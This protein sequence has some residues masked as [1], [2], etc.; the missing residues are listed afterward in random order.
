MVES[1][2]FFEAYR[3]VLERLQNMSEREFPFKKYIVECKKELHPPC[4]LRKYDGDPVKYDFSPIIASNQGGSCHRFGTSASTVTV[5]DLAS[6]PSAR[7]LGLDNS[8]FKALQLALTNEF[9]VIQGP[10]G[11]GKTYIG[12]KIAKILLHNKTVWR[13]KSTQ[14]PILVVCYTN[15]AL[16]QFLEEIYEFQKEGIVRVG[17]RSQSAL[18]K[19]CSLWETKRKMLSKKRIPSH[20]RS[21]TSEAQAKMNVLSRQ[22]EEQRRL[23]NTLETNVVDE[24]ELSQWSSSLT[25]QHY[26]TL[27]NGTTVHET[28]MSHWLGLAVEPPDPYSADHSK[29]LLMFPFN[30]KSGN[31]EYFS[32]VELAYISSDVQFAPGADGSRAGSVELCGNLDSFIQIANFEGGYADTAASITILAFLYPTGGHGPILCYQRNGYGLQIW[33]E[34]V[35]F[36]A[37][38]GTLCALFIRRDLAI[39]IPIRRTILNI[40]AWNFIGISYDYW[41]GVARLWHNGN[42]V[43]TVLIGAYFPL[44]TQ[45]PIRIGALDNPWQTTFFKGRI[46]HLHIYSEALNIED[47]RAVGCISPE[48]PQI[49]STE[50]VNLD[51]EQL[52]KDTPEE[53]K[54][55]L[56]IAEGCDDRAETEDD[57]PKEDQKVPDVR[58][59]AYV[60][61]DQ[62]ILD[63]DDDF[64]RFDKG[65]ADDERS[66]DDIPLDNI[67]H[68]QAVRSVEGGQ[69]QGGW[70]FQ[71]PARVRQKIKRTIQRELR[72]PDLLSEEDALVV[73]NVWNLCGKDRWRLYR[74]WVHDACETCHRKIAEL[75]VS[76]DE[77]ARN[78]KHF[79]EEEDKYVLSK[80]DV[81]GM[82]TTG[83]ARNQNV[84][85]AIKP[86]ITIVEEAAEVMEAHIITSLTHGCQHLILIGD[87]QQL[88]PNPN[89]YNLQI[90]YDFDVSL[91]E[92]MIKNGMEFATLC[93]QHRM[94]PEIAKLLDHIYVDPKL[95]NHDSVLKFESIRGVQ[96]NLFFLE[97][98]EREDFVNEGRSRS[99]THEAKFMTALCRYLIQQGY[100]Q[101]QITILAA[102]TGQLSKLKREMSSKYKKLFEGVRVSVV[103]NFQGEE[104]DIILLSLVRSERSGFLKIDNRVCV[105]LSRARKGFFIIGNST[106][107]ARESS[108]WRNIFKDMREQG[109]M[110]RELSLTCQNHPKNGIQASS[111]TDFDK[112]PKGGCLRPCG[113]TMECGHTCSSV[114][115][116]VDLE[117][118]EE[119][120]CQQPCSKIICLSGHKCRKTCSQECGPCMEIVTK[121]IPGCEHKKRLPCSVDVKS[122]KCEKIVPKEALPCG[123]VNEVPCSDDAASIKCKTI[124]RKEARPCGH[125]NKVLCSDDA[126]SIKCKTI[127][128]K[129]ARPCGHV[130]KVLCSDDAASIKCKTIVRKE[131]RPCGHVNKVLCSDDA[132]S[133]KC[134]TIVRKEARPCGHVNKVLCSD[135][136]ASI[137][138]KTIVRKEARP[139][140]HVNKVL[141]SDDA[142]SIKC[143]TIV[144]K[145][146]RP[147]GHVNKVLCS[148]DAA[149]IK[150]KTIVRKEARPCG[151]VNKVLCS[152]DAASIKCKTIVRKEARPCG[153]V[154]KVLCSDDAAS[155]KCKTIVR[156][157]AW[158]CG[159][160][161]E[162]PCFVMPSDIECKMPCDELQCGHK[163]FG[164]CHQCHQGRLH[165]PCQSKCDRSLFCGHSCKDDCSGVCPPCS[166][167]CENYCEHRICNKTCGD[168]C[169]PCEDKCSWQC[170]HYN[171]TK[172][173]NEPCNRPRCDQPCE[174]KLPCDHPCIGVCGEECPKL[175]RVCN[176]DADDFKGCDPQAMFVELMDC[177]HI[178]QVKTLDEL[179]DKSHDEDGQNGKMEI[180]HKMCPK[181]SKPILSSRRYGKIIKEILADFDAVKRQLI[182]SDVAASDQIKNIFSD[183]QQIKSCRHD[184]EKIV[185]KIKSGRVTPEEVVKL[186]NQVLFIKSLDS[187]IYLAR[188]VDDK[189]LLRE[190]YG[191]E[192][193]IMETSRCFSEQE[194]EE[195]VEEISRS[196][197]LVSF[198]YFMTGLQSK[199]TFL[200]PEDN[201]CILSIQETLDSGKVID[202]QRKT[203]FLADIDRIKRK[204]GLQ[205]Q[206]AGTLDEDLDLSEKLSKPKN[207]GRRPWYKCIEG[208]VYPAPDQIPAR[209]NNL[210]ASCPHCVE[211]AKSTPRTL[212][213]TLPPQITPGEIAKA[214]KP[215][216]AFSPGTGPHGH[217][218]RPSKNTRFRK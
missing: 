53:L 25:T 98:S 124:V 197:L 87:H 195:L 6:W 60:I 144:R 16:D 41:T 165:K 127:V 191:L 205:L 118:K 34:Q 130:N 96:R 136:A 134:K 97:H 186:Q 52:D 55:G 62:R 147:C 22:F 169:M 131:A 187:T 17:S 212:A 83:A 207:L 42:V 7:N 146:A 138:C 64:I 44:A 185:N 46:S 168:R 141:C 199:H 38:I 201:A 216:P 153:H 85:Q 148:D 109:A 75:Q 132:A 189:T 202:R 36:S 49:T 30:D 145:E 171:C 173:C 31:R 184:A 150:C 56:V 20:L 188:K 70:K 180:K 82:T 210:S 5:L 27:K 129:E 172:L 21:L 204:Y 157:E 39:A 77:E 193:R 133:I 63:G 114:C 28:V 140:G 156:K 206:D 8:Q 155:I 128:R 181:C 90:N 122:V 135:D 174:K 14:G 74:R 120:R 110:G 80:A 50:E 183:A 139:C 192:S 209:K 92:R 73:E 23:I 121:V 47:I 48:G 19:T 33:F 143:K 154:N 12:L 29:P 167:K 179:M 101:S 166:N 95:E 208:H 59:E 200:T 35:E 84:L 158:P 76:F 37:I 18:M 1:V 142:A 170:P 213:E 3:P 57:T 214:M 10:P 40:N 81:I 100:K 176:E 162:V 66:K 196:K 177:G 159:H 67:G 93:S 61:E 68:T 104:N 71:N 65:M 211:E 119:F 152:D 86:A 149:S 102:Y 94:R 108:L 89:V 54:A 99:N 106:V 117:H 2:A 182:T 190:V 164:N 161:N 79:K 178:F 160:V 69:Q 91:F 9:A 194:I 26:E 113:I 15:H 175:C 72:N 13:T 24:D 78:L 88:R 123:H 105:A 4:Y 32:N 163:C 112:A 151:H 115:H 111:A 137:K 107:L 103:D 45:F 217:R 51:S 198:R 116:P 11:T 215:Q 43:E 126:A 203:K 125:V 218:G 58:F